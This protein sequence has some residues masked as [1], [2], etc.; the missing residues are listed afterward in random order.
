MRTFMLLQSSAALL[1]L[2]LCG[3][4]GGPVLSICPSVCLCSGGHRVVDC[5][6]RG[7]TKLPPGLQH[8]IRSLN[9][10]FNRTWLAML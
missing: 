5:S 8:N 6:S 7:L 10:S 1:V 2:L 9:L 3:L 4:L